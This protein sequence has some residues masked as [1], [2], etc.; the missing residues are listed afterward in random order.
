[1]VN[2]LK[3]FYN[4]G[5]PRSKAPVHEYKD[6]QVLQLTHA[7]GLAA[8]RFR[9]PVCGDYERAPRCFRDEL[10]EPASELSLPSDKKAL[11]LG[12]QGIP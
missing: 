6:L 12:F 7:V 9:K 4:F 8:E 10:G 1:M 2:A 5:S 3:D 11:C